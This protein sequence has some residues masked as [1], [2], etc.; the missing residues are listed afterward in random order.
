MWPTYNNVYSESFCIFIVYFCNRKLLVYFHFHST[1]TPIFICLV[2]GLFLDQLCDRNWLIHFYSH[3]H[4]RFYMIGV[5]IVVFVQRQIFLSL[6]FPH[7]LSLL[8]VEGWDCFWRICATE[9]DVFTLGSWL[10]QKVCPYILRFNL[11]MV[12]CFQTDHRP[13]HC[14]RHRQMDK[15]IN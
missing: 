8:Y 12:F 11:L 6:S 3:I 14:H 4:F 10:R 13:H 7:S 5:E 15:Q 2:L 1:F 9:T